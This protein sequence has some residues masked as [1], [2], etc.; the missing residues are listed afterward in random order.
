MSNANFFQM[1]VVRCNCFMHVY[2]ILLIFSFFFHRSDVYCR[3]YARNEKKI[4]RRKQ[5]QVMNPW[6]KHWSILEIV[7]TSKL[8]QGIQW[9]KVLKLNKFNGI[10]KWRDTFIWIL[11]LHPFLSLSPAPS[12]PSKILLVKFDFY[13]QFCAWNAAILQFF[14]AIFFPLSQV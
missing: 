3:M 1:V 6:S 7:E 2:E 13:N 4:V 9:R 8:K 10:S 12:L 5:R 11:A 14:N